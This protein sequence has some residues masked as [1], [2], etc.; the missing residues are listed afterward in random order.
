PRRRRHAAFAGET[1]ARL[2]GKRSNRMRKVAL[3]TALF[4][5]A[6]AAP[7]AIA[8]DVPDRQVQIQIV[9]DPPSPAAAAQS[10]TLLADATTL[11]GKAMTEETASST[12]MTN[13][14]MER[15][16]AAA[17]RVQAAQASPASQLA[18]MARADRLDAE[19]AAHDVSSATFSARARLIRARAKALR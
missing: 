10:R 4:A 2:D 1:L 11:D 6:A 5:C 8:C 16:R 13:A 18:L 9:V 17:I 15:R 12:A 14:R 3:I 7:A 19:A